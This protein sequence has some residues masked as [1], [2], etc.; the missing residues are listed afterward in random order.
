MSG[1]VWL[2]VATVAVVAGAYAQLVLHSNLAVD[3]AIIGGVCCGLVAAIAFIGA[4]RRTGGRTR[5]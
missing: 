4:A 2:A 5:A 3:A 1:T